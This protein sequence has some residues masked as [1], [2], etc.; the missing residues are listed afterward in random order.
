MGL[1]NGKLYISQGSNHIFALTNFGVSYNITGIHT[2]NDIELHKID[3]GGNP[4]REKLYHIEGLHYTILDRT[5]V[6]VHMGQEHN[7][8]RMNPLYKTLANK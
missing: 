5:L 8:T 1:S 7:S 6:E 3:S 2:Q 4:I